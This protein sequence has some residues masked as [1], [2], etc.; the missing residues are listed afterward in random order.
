MLLL[1]DNYD[2]F[3]FNLADYFKQL[4]QD[5]RV[6]RNDEITLKE[7][8]ALKPTHIVISPGPGSPKD[9]GISIPLIQ[10]FAGHRPILGVCLGHQCIA[11]AFGASI[12]PAK[13]I[14]HG[15]LS[16][17]THNKKYLFKGIDDNFNATR[18][19]SLSIDK[20]TLSPDF[21]I[22][23]TTNDPDAEIMAIKHQHYPIFGV[24]FHPEAVLTEHGLNVLSNFVQTTCTKKPLA[25]KQTLATS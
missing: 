5:V 23:A 20:D 4:G 17:I 10:H 1:I 19:H 9:S 11:V 21:D 3:T 12:A 2:S 15:K 16:K 13:H 25:T 22:C 7:A 14:M 8:I 24:Q 18:Y 6:Y